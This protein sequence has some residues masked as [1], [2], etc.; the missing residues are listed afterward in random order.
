MVAFEAHI[1]NE[2][3]KSEVRTSEIECHALSPEALFYDNV[4]YV[5]AVALR[6]IGRP[7]EVDDIVQEV[8]AEAI[9]GLQT[10]RDQ[11]AIK[12]WLAIITV[13][14]AQRHLKRRDR[15]R[16]L[17]LNEEYDYSSLEATQVSPDDVVLVSELFRILDRLPPRQRIAWT[18][19]YV[20]GE[21]LERVAELCECSLSTVKRNVNAAHCFIQ[22][23]MKSG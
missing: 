12:G 1:E 8:F 16:F 6:I 3:H 17:K 18:L 4:R 11:G 9:Q 2:A 14:A 10:V 20:E 5:G 23:I 15:W 22:R 21:S 19:K 7:E 13:R